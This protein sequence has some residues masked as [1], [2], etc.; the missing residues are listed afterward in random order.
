MGEE[1]REALPWGYTYCFL[2][3]NCMRP[4]KGLEYAADARLAG[5]G[6]L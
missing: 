2:P 6:T 5:G 3:P 1:G 4:W